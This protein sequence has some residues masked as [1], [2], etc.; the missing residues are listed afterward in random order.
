MIAK[1]TDKAMTIR[2]PP[3]LLERLDVAAAGNGRSRNSEVI[4]RLV[5]SLGAKDRR[6][7]SVQLTTT[8]AKHES[9]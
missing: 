2:F 7:Q 6:K 9:Q 3:G 4:V 5:E 8:G 1:R